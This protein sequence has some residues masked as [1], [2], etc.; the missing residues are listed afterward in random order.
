MG[1]PLRALIV[2]DSESDLEILVRELERGGYDVTY[3]RVD[4]AAA[5]RAALDRPLWDLV[6]SDHVMPQFSAPA[7]LALV[8]EKRPGLP[9]IVLSGEIDLDLAVALMKAGVQDYVQKGEL[10]RLIPVIAREL[11]EVE[12]RRERQKAE[13]ALRES[14]EKYRHLFESSPESIALV[15]LDGVI[16]DCNAATTAISGLARTEMIGKPFTEIGALNEKDIPQYIQIFSQVI[17]GET[18]GPLQL[19]IVRGSSE[20]RWIEVFPASLRKDGRV[21][22]IQITTRDITERK[23]V[24]E[25]LRESEQRF[26]QLAEENA[27]LLEQARQNATTQATL[28]DEV[29]HRVK[30]NL[31]SIMGILAL[32]SQRSIRGGTDYRIALREMQN[33]IQGMAAV[34]EM[35]SATRWSPLPLA[36]LV[37]RIIHEA[38]SNSSMRQNIQVT[39]TPPAEPLLIAPRQATA[40]ALIINELTTN[41]L[42]H[43]FQERG[44]GCIEARIAAEGEDGRQVRLEFRNDGPDWPDDVLNG[45]RENVGLRLVRATVRSPLRGKIVLCNDNGAVTLITFELAAIVQEPVRESL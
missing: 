29:N 21:Y 42:K 3:E 14:E 24:E 9:I 12:A 44:R 32:E 35:L 8:K 39:V 36:D 2:E 23:Q 22:A 17:G 31:A 25:A 41:S 38:L 18:I 10:A 43:A 33:R 30:N 20:L 27:G 4:T 5:M 19:Q 34:H 40:L 45:Q 1:T 26:R 37:T 7:A 13:E 11:R 15:G 28:L 6:I 16:L